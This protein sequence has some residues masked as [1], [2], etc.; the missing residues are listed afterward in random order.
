MILI[1]LVLLVVVALAAVAAVHTG[2]DVRVHVD[3]YGQHVTT[4]VLWVFVAGAVAMLLL[5]LAL[6][7]F[8]RAARRRRM[9]RRELKAQRADE[10]AAEEQRAADARAA[11][12][13]H[14]EARE[15]EAPG[16][17]VAATSAAHAYQADDDP[18][19]ERRYVPGDERQG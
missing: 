4:S 6:A 2:Q 9:R 3:G 1:G 5:V 16:A 17:P 14:A 13:R 18:G 7:A 11:D 19:P 8:A 15:T 10:A 12:A